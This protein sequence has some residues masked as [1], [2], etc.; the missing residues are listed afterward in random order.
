MMESCLKGS[1]E[2]IKEHNP[3]IIIDSN[4]DQPKHILKKLGYKD[5]GLEYNQKGGRYIKSR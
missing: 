3:E 2:T 4:L 1:L 5:I